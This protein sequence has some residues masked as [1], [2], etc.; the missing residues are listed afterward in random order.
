ML[1]LNCSLIIFFHWPLQQFK[2]STVKNCFKDFD[3]YPLFFPR[4][5][6]WQTSH[7]HK[8]YCTSWSQPLN[9]SCNAN[10]VLGIAGLRLIHGIVVDFEISLLYR[11]DRVTIMLC[12]HFFFFDWFSFWFFSPD[13]SRL[14]D[15]IFRERMMIY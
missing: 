3:T 11:L 10:F 8:W 9:T 4:N 5:K 14:D 12:F 13:T 15:F 6:A 7:K 1:Y 2:R